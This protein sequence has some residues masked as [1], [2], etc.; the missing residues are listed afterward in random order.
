MDIR[1]KKRVEIIQDLFSYTFRKDEKS[2]QNPVSSEIVK[3]LPEIDAQIRL[4]ATKFPI[5]KIA[6][7][8]LSILRLAIY[9]LKINPHEPIKVV[10]NEAVELA[11]EFG[12]E[13]SFAFVN[14]VLGK[15]L[16]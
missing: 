3:K 12:G 10:I 5:E 9:E 6:K 11:K 16:P 14:A 8:D 4:F 13:K 15:L 1:H 7:T 2:F